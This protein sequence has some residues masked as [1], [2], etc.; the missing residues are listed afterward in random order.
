MSYPSKSVLQYD[1]KGVYKR[2]FTSV[3]AAAR[4]IN[5]NKSSITKAIMRKGTSGGYYWRFKNGATHDI[6]IPIQR[7]LGVTV[8][9]FYKDSFCCEVSSIQE[10]FELTSIPPSTIRYHL[11]KSKITNSKFTFERN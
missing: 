7:R 2:S 8:K 3:S 4:R 9:I 5:V 11:D 6:V 10:A 1:K